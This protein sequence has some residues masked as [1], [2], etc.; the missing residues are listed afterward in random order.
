MLVR[1]RA[2]SATL[3]YST[4]TEPGI[5]PTFNLIP[6]K[7]APFIFVLGLGVYPG[8]TVTSY[9]ASSSISRSAHRNPVNGD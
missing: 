7:S 8:D 5:S 6:C 3:R 4:T 1:P 9:S 2:Y